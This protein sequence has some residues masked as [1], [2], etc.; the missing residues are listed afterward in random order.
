MHPISNS[1]AAFTGKFSA[2]TLSKFQTNLSDK[3]FKLVK[4]FRAGKRY[5][6]IDIITVNKEP[7]RLSTGTVV[8]GKE[9]YADFS[10][11]K[12]KKGPH[13]RIKLSDRALPFSID[14]FKLIT[15]DLVKRGEKLMEMFR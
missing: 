6:N 9:T 3:D 8:C 1:Q 2:N 4:N 12:V 11:A 15:A 5:T 10:S 14:T 13:A 7:V